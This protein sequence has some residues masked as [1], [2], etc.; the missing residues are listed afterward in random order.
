M[1]VLHIINKLTGGGAERQLALLVNNSPTDIS[2]TI[3]YVEKGGEERFNSNVILFRSD[4]ITK[5]AR[6]RDAYRAVDGRYN[7]VQLWLPEYLCIP[8]AI[9]AKIKGVAT[10]SCDRRAPSR[11]FSKIYLRDRA[12]LIYHL[13]SSV[14]V[15][16]FPVVLYRG[17]F[18][19]LLSIK[20]LVT[21]NN[22][23]IIDEIDEP[24][25]VASHV[26]LVFV[27]R[28]VNQKR[29]SICLDVLE[30]LYKQFNLE[31]DS[32]HLHFFGTGE[33]ESEL[34]ARVIKL[35]MN[36]AVSFHGFTSDWRAAVAEKHTTP[37]M[38]FPTLNEGMPNVL[39]EAA[40]ASIP[41]IASNIREINSHFISG[42]DCQ[43]IDIHGRE[44]NDFVAAIKQLIAN[45]AAY[46]EMASNAKKKLASY[47][48]E[49][50]SKDWKDLYDQVVH[51]K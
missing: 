51:R 28:M 49:T 18:K 26:N 23:V 47:D 13:L 7:I 31:S 17:T 9:A 14:V 3:F 1:R 15:T 41:F 4:N 35:G 27:G 40:S 24:K 21:I 25:F 12:K 34:K 29:P 36:S 46:Q 2:H 22:I 5:Y 10:V 20:R 11:E 33:L 16:N 43:L 32:V 37:I 45:K 8:A 50:I 42:V 30:K 6:M 38:I 44:I 19:I 48:A 39:F